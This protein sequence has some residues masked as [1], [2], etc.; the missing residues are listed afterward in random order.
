MDEF[1]AVLK[2]RTLVNKV[3]PQSIPVPVESYAQE[4]NAL[5]RPDSDLGP[6]EPG[7]SFPSNGKH[8]VCPNPQDKEERQRFTICHELAHIAMALP[9]QHDQLPWWSYAKRPLAEIFCDIFAAELLLPHHLFKPLAEKAP[10]GLSAIDDLAVR[11]CA[12][13][14]AAGSRFAALISTPCAFVISEKGKV[15]YASRSTSLREANAW[16]APRIELPV[17]SLSARVRAGAVA[18]A[19]EEIDAD[20]WFSDWERGGVVIEEARHLAK[21][22]QTVTLL[23][24]EDEEVPQERRRVEDSA[25]QDT[26]LEELDGILR[27]KD[28][29]GGRY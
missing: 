1:G 19:G 26:D 16:I 3:K 12:S 22:D 7:Y 28:K 5:I 23:W 10:I 8:F 17:G 11:F 20:V 13:N 4:L 21:W 15:R 29:R 24:F 9:S 14:T 27:F 18:S 6:D 25:E 2:A